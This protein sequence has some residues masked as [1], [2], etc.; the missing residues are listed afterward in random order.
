MNNDLDKF[1]RKNKVRKFHLFL[2]DGW[3]ALGVV[4]GSGCCCC[5]TGCTGSVAWAGLGFGGGIGGNFYDV[6]WLRGT[7]RQ[8]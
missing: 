7:I 8:K 1:W 3:D 2:T 5:G 6:K 4:W